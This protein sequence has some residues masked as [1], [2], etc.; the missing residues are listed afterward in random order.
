MDFEFGETTQSTTFLDRNPK[1][2]PAFERVVALTNKCFVRTYQ[3]KNRMEDIC[4]HLGQTC[5]Q[6]FLEI[7]F[8]A[9]NGYGIA[10]SKVLRGLYERTVTVAYLVKHPE[11]T[12]R[13]VNFAAIQE[14]KAVNRA[15]GTVSQEEFDKVI[16]PDMVQRIRDSYEQVKKEFQVTR[17]SK[18]GHKGTAISW[19]L[20]FSSMVRDVGEPFPRYYLGA[21][22]IPNLQVHATLASAQIKRPDEE[23]MA[24]INRREG[25]FA[26]LNATL[27]FL[28]AIR[29]QDVLFSLNLSQDIE[30]CELDVESVWHKPEH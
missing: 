30:A 17:C 18:C 1:F 28:L 5:R 2:I 16:P 3:P 20:D 22:E 27:I 14:H 7:V 23:E 19:D 24:E 11:K 12:D 9:V 21:Y 6:D 29:S 15:L 4:F 25:D 10:A 13:F 8:L 26:L